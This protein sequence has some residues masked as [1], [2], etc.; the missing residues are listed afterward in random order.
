MSQIVGWPNWIGVVAEN[1]ERQRVF[2]GDVLGF[3][4]IGAGDGWVWFDLGWPMLLEVLQL[5]PGKPQYEARRYQAGF[6]TGHIL[7]TIELLRRRG[8][9]A[10]TQP[11]GGP[12]SGGM[13]AYYRDIEGNLFEVSQRFG[14]PWPR[15]EGGRPAAIVGPPVW[16]GIVARD[17][18]KT[19]A[20]V[21]ET[22]G[23]RPLARSDWWSWFDLGWPNLFEV[24]GRDPSRRQYA[25]PGWQVAFSI[26]SIQ[27]A[28]EELIRRGAR[29]LHDTEGG[30]DSAGYWCHFLDAEENVFA[31]TQRL[32]P[33]WPAQTKES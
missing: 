5:E 22:F 18:A 21:E 12:G 28:R 33:P 29:P 16:A 25:E 3:R 2:Y 6:S 19:S 20:W 24:I 17:V 14:P 32:G 31:I 26:S 27:D 11:E 13:W 30:P 8:V 15:D 1:L 7:D 4:E 9:E 10:V 23:F